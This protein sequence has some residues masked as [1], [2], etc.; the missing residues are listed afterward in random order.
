M[1]VPFKS[2]VGRRNGRFLREGGVKF[3]L[4]NPTSHTPRILNF[5]WEGGRGECRILNY[6]DLFSGGG[7]GHEF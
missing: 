1:T 3:E 4:F 7:G 2:V 5:A 6:F